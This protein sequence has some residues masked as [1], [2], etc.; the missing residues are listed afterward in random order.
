MPNATD[1]DNRITARVPQTTKRTIE[2]AAGIVGATMNQFIVQAAF[3]KAEE[4]IERARVLSFSKKEVDKLVKIMS[5]PAK[6]NA[7]L[8]K[9]A[10]RHKELL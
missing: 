1:K 10:K 9:A 2:E 6:P 7:S 4:I 8:K 5:T 3:E